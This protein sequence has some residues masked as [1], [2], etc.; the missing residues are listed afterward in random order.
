MDSATPALAV[1]LT[2]SDDACASTITPAL[3]V[4]PA[5]KTI[6]VA[7]VSPVHQPKI[8]LWPKPAELSEEL[9]QIQEKL[10]VTLQCLLAIRAANDL[11]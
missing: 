6:Q 4:S 2:P 7:S 11:H 1:T 8:S 9:V 3:P 10:T 5:P